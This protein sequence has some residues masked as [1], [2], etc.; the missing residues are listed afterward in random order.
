[1]AL[2]HPIYVWS[3]V[4][5]TKEL[6]MPER[7][8]IVVNTPF[9]QWQRPT[10][11]GAIPPPPAGMGAGWLAIPQ[12]KAWLHFGKYLFP[13]PAVQV[14]LTRTPLE[15]AMIRHV[16]ER[17]FGAFVAD[18]GVFNSPITNEVVCD[19]RCLVPLC[20]PRSP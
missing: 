8:P 19:A 7:C 15:L 1:M 2:N 18:G 13:M 17:L 16:W 4:D 20:C 5:N 14:L 6:L 12:W 9:L 11:L 3:G 10:P